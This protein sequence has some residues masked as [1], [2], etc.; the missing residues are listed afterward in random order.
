MLDFAM[1]SIASKLFRF[2]MDSKHEL[3][4]SSSMEDLLQKPSLLPIAIII[5]YSCRFAGSD[6]LARHVF[7][8]ISLLETLVA[9]FDCTDLE[10]H[11]FEVFQ[12]PSVKRSMYGV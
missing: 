9:W 12:R 8:V 5:V 4:N 10:Q 11:I 2:V 7:R 6:G 1:H 3:E